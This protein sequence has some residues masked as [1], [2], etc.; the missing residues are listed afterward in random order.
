VNYITPEKRRQAA[1]LV[2]TGEIVSLARPIV[3]EPRHAEIARDGRPNGVPFYEMTFR[4]FPK[5]D[6][7]GNEDFTSDVQSFAPH[8][9]LLTHLDALCHYSNG[10]GLLYNGFPLDTTVSQETG[11][12]RLGLDT[13]KQGIVTRGILIDMTALKAPRVAAPRVYADDIEAFEKQAGITVSPG[14]ALFVYDPAPPGRPRGGIDASVVPW[15][16]DRGVTLTSGI[17]RVP[18]DPHGDHR[19]PLVAAGIF[20]LDSPDLATL[21]ATARR[22]QRWEFMLTIAPPLA[23]GATG[24]PVNPLAMF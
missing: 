9:A 19:L 3:L 14:D 11:C 21:A 5:G 4:T 16:K 24:Y 8:G 20:L 6:P 10:E 12:T 17:A 13:L 2:R 18:D 15:M 1:S 22:L 7:R 23:P